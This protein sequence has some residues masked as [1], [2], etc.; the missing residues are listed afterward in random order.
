MRLLSQQSK[1]QGFP[2]SLL[3]VK[4]LLDESQS[5]PDEVRVVSDIVDESRRLFPKRCQSSLRH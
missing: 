2:P 4:L 5:R 3:T 1:A